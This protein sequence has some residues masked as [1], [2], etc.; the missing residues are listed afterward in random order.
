MI[1]WIALGF[2]PMYGGLEFITR[3][4]TKRKLANLFSDKRFTG[5]EM[6]I[7]GI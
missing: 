7:N 1:G 2:L 4:V 6:E 3:K 5:R